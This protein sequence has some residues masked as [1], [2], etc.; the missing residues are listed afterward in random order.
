LKV[1]RSKGVAAASDFNGFTPLILNMHISAHGDGQSTYIRAV[2][3]APNRSLIG[4]SSS[5]SSQQDLRRRD[6]VYFDTESGFQRTYDQ[7]NLFRD[8]KQKIA[9]S[10]D[11]ERPSNPPKTHPGSLDEAT[12][13]DLTDAQRPRSLAPARWDGITSITDL[14]RRALPAPGLGLGGS[15]QLVSASAG[16]VEA[17]GGASG[18]PNSGAGPGQDLFRP[19]AK[20]LAPYL[21]VCTSDMI[22]PVPFNVPGTRVKACAMACKCDDGA[23]GI[24]LYSTKRLTALCSVA[25]EAIC[26]WQIKTISPSSPVGLTLPIH[27]T[28]SQIVACRLLESRP[29]E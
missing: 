28:D 18:H 11:L 26:P 7:D 29:W 13:L 15:F 3:S 19:Y 27:F 6:Q 9:A 2:P 22:T 5:T 1:P 10:M 14:C 24:G 23:F 12:I 17:G 4:M 25:A 8:Q 21:R 16:G 20:K